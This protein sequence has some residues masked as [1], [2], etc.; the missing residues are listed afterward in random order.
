MYPTGKTADE[1][2]P[3]ARENTNTEQVVFD[4]EYGTLLY[5][6]T[7]HTSSEKYDR[8]RLY[9]HNKTDKTVKFEMLSA[10]INGN[11]T[12]AVSYTHLRAH[13]TG[14]NLVCRLLLEKKKKK[15]NNTIET[16]K[17]EK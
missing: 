14:R 12:T 2:T 4:N 6:D 13:E 15:K 7:D 8:L 16:K 5:L 3:P 11:D 10:K 17:K 1:I 9:A